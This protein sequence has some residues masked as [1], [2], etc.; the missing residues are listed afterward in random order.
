M[1][2][3]IFCRWLDLNHR[4]LELE[5]TALPTEPQ[6]LPFK[7]VFTFLINH[8]DILCTG[9]WQMHLKVIYL[10]PLLT[11]LIFNRFACYYL[12]PSSFNLLCRL[13]KKR[14]PMQFEKKCLRLRMINRR[15]SNGD[16]LLMEETVQPIASLVGRHR[17]VG[18]CQTLNTILYI[19]R[20]C[21]CFMWWSRRQN[22]NLWSKEHFVRW[23]GWWW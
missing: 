11:N 23:N 3:K 12:L 15:D 19:K 21:L 9:R 13:F 5:A 10:D 16:P 6:P 2:N 1:F 7:L 4:P 22:W 14:D 8:S 18:S 20:R 17:Y